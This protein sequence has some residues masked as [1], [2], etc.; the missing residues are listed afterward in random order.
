VK[1]N[2]FKN[3]DEKSRSSIYRISKTYGFQKFLNKQ[4]HEEVNEN[5]EN[6]DNLQE[7]TRKLQ[8]G[9][10]SKITEGKV[11]LKDLLY[12]KFRIII[13]RSTIYF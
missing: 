13:L 1:V 5:N 9:G 2:K 11:G 6:K 8:V 10:G 12:L 4:Y 7:A 3:A